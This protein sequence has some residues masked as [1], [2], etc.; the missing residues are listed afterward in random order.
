MERFNENSVSMTRSALSQ[1][2]P[3]EGVKYS[4]E[5]SNQNRRALKE[6]NSLIGRNQ[7][8]AVKDKVIM[9][10]K[11]SQGVI[12]GNRPITRKFAATLAS[13]NQSVGN[14]QGLQEEPIGNERAKRALTISE[15]E[16][17]FSNYNCTLMEYNNISEME[18]VENSELKEI[19]MEDITEEEEL[20]EIV[21]SI[22]SQDVKNPLAVTEYVDEIYDFYW[23]TEDLRCVNPSY[24]SNQLDINEKMR[25][26]LIDWL[27]EV[28]YKLELLD[29]TLFLTV[30]IIDRFL[31]VQNVARKKLQLVGVTALLLACK[32]EEVSVPVVEDLILICDR[33]YSR[34]EVL[35]MERLVVNTLQFNMSVPT[36]YV[37]MRRFLKAAGSD[38]QLELLSFFMV[39]LCLVEYSMLQY[40]PSFLAAAAIF[41]AQ[42]S[43][44]GFSVWTKSSQLHSRYSEH[45]LLECSRI[46]V[47][48][49]Q[50]A[51]Q[52]KLTGV[53]RKY[54]TYKYGCASKSEPAAFLL[55]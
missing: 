55:E 18:V 39:E 16:D 47:E 15:K 2:A 5:A 22:D 29:E 23:R 28:H 17:A 7:L 54:S 11:N 40:R 42:S 32:Y 24:M 9:N 20:E 6:I 27:I 41:T 33:A 35:D 51:G 38:R 14:Y 36:P 53:H 52:G 46:M 4:V 45:E 25:A 31:A 30:N 49:H 12:S 43:L 34:S 44:N 3:M 10:S 37:F 19:E 13:Q 8:G 50:K 26:I 21:P 48:L 1:G